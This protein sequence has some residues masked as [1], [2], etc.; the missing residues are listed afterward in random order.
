[1]KRTKTW[2]RGIVPI[3]LSF[4]L[5]LAYEKAMAQF[6]LRCDGFSAVGGTSSVTGTNLLAVGG[7]PHPIGTSQALVIS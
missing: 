6:Q 2:A 4:L 1:M 3:V 7:Q 5:L